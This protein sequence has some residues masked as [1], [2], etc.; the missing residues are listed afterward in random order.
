MV[1]LLLLAPL[2]VLLSGGSSPLLPFR[3][4]SH[5]HLARLAVVDGHCRGEDSAQPANLVYPLDVDGKGQPLDLVD[6]DK[7]A[8][9][10]QK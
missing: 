6:V 1:A 3:L 5:T 7:G 8:M 10:A 9:L 2:C 4:F